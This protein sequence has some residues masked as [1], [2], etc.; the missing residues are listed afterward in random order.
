MATFFSDAFLIGIL[1]SALGLVFGSFG[2]V[3]ITRMPKDESLGGRSHCPHCRHKLHAIELIPLIS[4]L[5]QGGRCRHCKAKI[6]WQ[7]PLLELAVMG[8]FLSAG[9]ATS[10]L[11]LPALALAFVFW[12]MLMIGIVDM[13]T[14]TI[15]DVLTA[16]L[17]ISA[18]IFHVAI[19]GGI[20]W[21]GAL[22]GVVFFGA[23]WIFSRGMWVGSGDI[24]LA[25]ALGILLGSWKHSIIML[26]VAYIVGALLV[27]VLLGL[28]RMKR[29][30]N[31]AFGPFLV[32][33][34]VISFFFADQILLVVLPMY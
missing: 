15:P 23:Q 19:G 1:L 9:F 24:L 20:P 12:S 4:F 6:S 28:G 31:I 13:R 25:A 10:F 27:S 7:Y 32:L 34:A 22:F 29:T 3:L 21:T 33:G 16:V 8:L 17:A 18:A 5:V 14:Q 26:M 11:F 30:Q 2:S